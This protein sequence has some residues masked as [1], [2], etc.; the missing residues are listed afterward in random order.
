MLFSVIQGG[1]EFDLR[2]K[3]TKELI[4]IGFDGYGF[5]AMPIDKNGILTGESFSD[6]NCLIGMDSSNKEYFHYNIFNPIVLGCTMLFNSDLKNFILPIKLS[7]FNHDRFITIIAS[8][9]PITNNFYICPVP[10]ITSRDC[11]CL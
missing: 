11:Y 6:R 1:L 9:I 2:E 5:G 7:I 3:C 10:P 8:N 4:N